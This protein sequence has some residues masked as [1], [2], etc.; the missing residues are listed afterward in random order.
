M[1]AILSHASRTGR[2]RWLIWDSLATLLAISLIYLLWLQNF[3]RV[4]LY[5]YSVIAYANGYL[6]RGM[7]PYRDFGTPLQTLTYYLGYSSEF[8]FGRRYLALG[9]G[10]LVLTYVLFASATILIRRTLSYVWAVV[11]AG[12]LCAATTLQHGILW[13][14]ALG[15]L[16]LLWITFLAFDALERRSL[17][18]FHVGGFAVLFLLTGTLKLNYHLAAIAIVAFCLIWL[19]VQ[20][21]LF[22]SR[23]ALIAV[24]LAVWATAAPVCL[25]LLT[26]GSSFDVWKLNV[27]VRPSGRARD[28]ILLKSHRF[29]FGNGRGYYPADPFT[30]LFAVGLLCYA[31]ASFLMFRKHT[32]AQYVDVLN[33]WLALFWLW[34][35]FSLAV[36]LGLTNIDLGSAEATLPVGLLAA[37]IL[38]RDLPS[39]RMLQRFALILVV[40]LGC[41]GVLGIHKHSRLLIPT[42]VVTYGV[43]YPVSTGY[44][45]G[46]LLAELNAEQLADARR[47]VEKYQVKPGSAEIYWGPG[48]EM[49]YRQFQGRPL[50]GFPLWYGPVTVR[51]AD[52]EEIVGRLQASPVRIFVADEFWYDLFV[53]GPMKAWLDQHWMRENEGSLLLFVRPSRK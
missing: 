30:G 24:V 8:V 42:Q 52:V 44:M 25:E 22:T 45:N 20:G 40:W 2:K 11:T 17:K 46:A 27:L 37:C 33:L 16:L 29:W 5:D 26:T 51:D 15:V 10:N 18:W 47:V 36:L 6:Q 32:K 4:H 21:L 50:S 49:F 35:F 12:S 3:G 34:I 53:P 31:A 28:V 38:F 14:N 1:I 41:A 7:R 39:K 43:T 13:Y 48:T 23:F 9:Y 19:R